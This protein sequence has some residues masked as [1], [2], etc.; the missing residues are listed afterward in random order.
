MESKKALI[1]GANG[2]VGGELLKLLLRGKE[3]DKV[4][5]L[6]RKPL[7]I[8]DA[9]LE[10]KIIDFNN[11]DEATDSFQVNHVF[12]CLGTTIKKAKSKEVFKQV[13][14]LY[15]LEMAKIAKEKQVEKFLIISSM[16][17]NSDSLVFY[18]RMKGLL[19]NQLQSIGFNSLHIL[20]PSLLLGNRKDYRPGE[21]AGAFLTNLLSFA[22]IGPLKKYKPIAA[23]TVAL[24][25]FEIAQRDVI[26]VHIY[27]SDEIS[28]S[29]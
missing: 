13:D 24:A 5:A 8:K 28:K 16:G 19:E 23:E 27:P 6:V 22:F 29:T 12:C 17:A 14:V 25:M 11:M 2:L 21:A 7:G 9:K 4:V 10:E 20:R 18:S 3:Y 26:G 1:A 15:P